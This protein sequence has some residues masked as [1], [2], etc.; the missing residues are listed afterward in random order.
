MASKLTKPFYVESVGSRYAIIAVCYATAES[1][2]TA[3]I[4]ASS[5]CSHV[6]IWDCS[7]SPVGTLIAKCVNGALLK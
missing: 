4:T 7:L 2:L 5:D 1:A 6:L 3:A